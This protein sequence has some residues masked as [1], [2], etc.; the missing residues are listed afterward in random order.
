MSKIVMS[1]HSKLGDIK[2]NMLR[3]RPWRYTL[4]PNFNAALVLLALFLTRKDIML[5]VKE[6]RRLFRVLVNYATR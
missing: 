4:P 6:I 1:I 2:R 3:T 5:R